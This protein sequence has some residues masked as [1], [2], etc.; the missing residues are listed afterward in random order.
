MKN[1]PEQIQR[2]AALDIVSHL[3]HSGYTALFA[4]GCVRDMLMGGDERGDID[5]VTNAT[6]QTVSALF[7][8]T[9]AVGAQFGVVVVVHRGIPFEVATFRSDI[10]TDDG[11]HPSHIVFT[12]AEHDALRRDFTINGMFYN[13]LTDKVFDYVSGKEDLAAKV[14]R[15]I[16]DPAL[17]FKEDYLRLLRAVRFAAR[18][19]FAIEDATWEAVKANAAHITGIS[20]E[21]IFAEHDRMLRKPNPDRAFRLLE[22]S[23]LLAR[24]IPEVADLRD[25][26]QPAQFHPEGDAFAHTIKALGLLGPHPSSVLSWSVLL[27]DIGKKATMR[28]TDRIRFNNHDQVGAAMAETVLQ[29]LRAPNSLI[30][31]VSACI[32]NH[33]NFMNVTDMRLSTLKKF[34]SRPTIAEELELHRVDCLASHGNLDNYDFIKKNLEAFALEQLKPQPLLRGNDL[35]SF[36]LAPGPVFGTI[37]DE[38]YDLQLEEK[39]KTRD[40]ALL[41]VKEKWVDKNR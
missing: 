11:R 33:M 37:L 10:G 2:Q 34:L 25:V 32:D 30:E 7:K 24:T 29:R 17:R 13:P 39:I 23:G 8:H 16:G 38:I 4:G 26:A 19:G 12:D 15:A 41:I 5:I 36:G 35:I 20:P 3:V 6:P 18:F 22:E 28:V 27:H 14:V 21:R 31:A 40:E 1:N 9:V